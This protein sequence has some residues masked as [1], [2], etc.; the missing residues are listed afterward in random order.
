[1]REKGISMKLYF[2][3]I[4][5]LLLCL[6][7]TAGFTGCTPEPAAPVN[8][9]ALFATILDRVSFDSELA[10]AGETT[11]LY[12]S[13]MPAGAE[14]VLYIGSGYFADEAVLVTVE[15]E[16]DTDAVLTLMEEHLQERRQEFSN[17]LPE[18]VSKIDNAVLWHQGTTVILC[19][20]ADTDT[21]DAI[22][23]DPANPEYTVPVT[24]ETT[25]PPTDPTEPPTQPP[26]DPTEPSTQPPTDPTEPST[27]PPTDPT[28]PSTQP[29]T[30]P[31]E[32][33]LPTYDLTSVHYY[34]NGTIRVGNHAYENYVY[35]ESSVDNYTSLINKA[36][37]QLGEGIN[38]YHLLIPTAVGIV[39]PDEALPNYPGFVDQGEAI[40]KVFGK[41]SERVIKVTCFDNLRAHRDEYLYFRTDYHWN[42]PAAYYAYESF[43]QAK[44]I[45][46]YT[47]SE[48]E[49]YQFD[50]FLGALY[51]LSCDKDPVIGAYP[52]TVIAYGPKSPDVRMTITDKNGNTYGWP[53]IVNVSDWASGS[54]Y[55]CYAGSDKPF[56]VFENP[57]VTDGSACIVVKES[58]GNAL[59]SYITDHY[60]TVYEIDYRYW[61]GN[62]AEFAKNN[63]VTDVIFAN[64]MS[65]T[66]NDMLIGMLG[67]ILD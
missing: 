5:A 67:G 34:K 60:S 26:T 4:F 20:T 9:Q 56:T 22:L 58:F 31:T 40:Q 8:A 38:V 57:A 12:F 30:E 1:M 33:T 15:S 64:N 51:W 66:R 63:G 32:P 17:Y 61:D 18:E 27:Q 6:A 24:Q 21:V 2:R 25:E 7:L 16:A 54:K 39:L 45:T 37:E 29:P 28:E 44:G 3:R 42:G 35:V 53:V 52:D 23:S 62:L 50:G 48:R 41:V 11:A 65:M 49:E 46:P 10:N 55:N 36:A 14:L 47:M 19:I 43:C 59:L 13:R